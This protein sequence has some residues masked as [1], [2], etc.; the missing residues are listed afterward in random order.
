M[1]DIDP[2]YRQVASAEWD[3]I[4]RK[5]SIEQLFDLIRFNKEALI[6]FDE[7]RTRL[8]LHHPNYRGFQEIPIKKIVGSVGRYKD[9]TRTFLPRYDNL[10]ERW[11]RVSAAMTAHGTPAIK[12]YKVGDAYFVADGNHR[13]SVARAHGADSIEAE[14]WEY[15]TAVPLSHHATLG[16]V[17]RKAELLN[18]YERTRLNKLIPDNQ[19]H[20]T[21]LGRTLEIEYQIALYRKVL[22]ET[23]GQP[24]PED[25]A[26]IE[27]YNN[28][29]LPTIEIIKKEN[30]LR[31]FPGRTPA[32][33]FA[34][35]SRHRY[36]LS[37]Q[38][39]LP[40]TIDDFAKQMRKRG[41]LG[42]LRRRNI[43]KDVGDT[44]QQP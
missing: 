24:C 14:V 19:I 2:Y 13:I 39:D 35:L 5:A 6:P 43:K 8:K 44:R 23:E 33:L 42:W 38:Y 22:E 10:R 15:P 26:V 21:V 41:P 7:V 40:V 29:Y 12:L 25:R 20:L 9:F 1:T 11:Q 30:L 36:N 18:F 28:I 37:S 4:K 17:L 16:E 3:N 32:D 27:W 31:H 34:W